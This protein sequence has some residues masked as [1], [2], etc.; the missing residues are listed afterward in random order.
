MKKNIKIYDKGS[1]CRHEYMFGEILIFNVPVQH[2]SHGLVAICFSAVSFDLN[3]LFNFSLNEASNAGFWKI[4]LCLQGTNLCELAPKFITF[5]LW[6]IYWC[7]FFFFITL[8]W[9]SWKMIRTLIQLSLQLTGGEIPS[10]S[11]IAIRKY[12]PM[13]R[14]KG[15]VRHQT[16][17]RMQIV[18][19]QRGGPRM[20]ALTSAY[21]LTQEVERDEPNDQTSCW[22]KMRWAWRE[23]GCQEQRSAKMETI[24]MKRAA[25]NCDNFRQ[26]KSG[27]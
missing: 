9:I 19:E 5:C 11:M 18:K 7:P 13:C 6:A 24:C 15:C 26:I 25:T 14:T 23:A 16:C 10:I 4:F 3:L 1:W 27:R 20:E 22:I 17:I 8:H 12:A 21:C 2:S